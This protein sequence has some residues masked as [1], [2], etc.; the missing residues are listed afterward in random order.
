MNLNEANIILKMKT[1]KE[2]KL[3]KNT[4]TWEYGYKT[5]DKI[6]AEQI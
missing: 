1:T 2:E 3:K 4:L 6:L 5:L